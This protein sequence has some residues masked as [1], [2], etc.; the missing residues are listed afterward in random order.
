MKLT[1][2]YQLIND[3]KLIDLILQNKASIS[4]VYFSWGDLPNGRR[5]FTLS[6]GCPPWEA[7]CRLVEDL[8]TLAEHGVGLNLL[9]NGNCYGE[10]SLSK[11]LLDTIGDIVDYLA[12]EFGFIESQRLV[13]E[14]R[15]ITGLRCREG[16]SPVSEMKAK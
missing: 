4:E 7:Q 14:E 11:Y 13:K 16:G 5:P 12:G 15:F 1:V 6:G 10:Y 9:L 8:R 2:G 3:R